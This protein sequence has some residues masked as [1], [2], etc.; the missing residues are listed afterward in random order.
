VRKI[1]DICRS[2]FAASQLKC[3]SLSRGAVSHA[4]THPRSAALPSDFVAAVE[5]E[6][7]D[8]GFSRSGTG[9]WLK[10]IFRQ[11]TIGWLDAD[12]FAFP[13]Q[14]SHYLNLALA[15]GRVFALCIRNA[16]AYAR[17]EET[18]GELQHEVN[19]RQQLT[20]E[21]ESLI[22]QLQENLAKIKTLQGLLPIC[23]GCKKIRDADGN[24]NPVEVYVQARTDARFSH[25]MCPDCI[26][27]WFPGVKHEK[28]TDSGG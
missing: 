18:V 22:T 23:A 13:E 19:E 6:A 17:I 15:M 21:R 4:E 27:K 10:L 20:R 3:V 26:P 11:E 5:K 9:F 8:F 7:G 25:G 14:K 28:S 24:W 12:G 16:R 2:L 1:L